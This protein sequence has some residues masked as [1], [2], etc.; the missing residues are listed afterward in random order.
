MQVPPKRALPYFLRNPVASLDLPDICCGLYIREFYELQTVL[1]INSIITNAGRSSEVLEMVRPS[2]PEVNTVFGWCHQHIYR[3][4]NISQSDAFSEFVKLITLKLFSDRHIQDTNPGVLWQDRFEIMADDVRFSQAWVRQNETNIPNP[5]SEILFKKFMDEMEH[6]IT[7]GTRKRIFEAGSQIKLKPETIQGVVKKLEK[8]FL[9]GID[10]DLNGRLFEIFLNATMRGKDLGQ[11]FT[12]R[13]VVKLG[14]KLAQLKVD[15]PLQDGSRH[16]DLVLDACCGTGGFLIDALANMQVKVDARADLADDRKQEMK[17]NIANKAIVGV[18][19]ANAPILARIARVNM[20]LHGDGGMRIFHLNA[21][22]PQLADVDTDTAEITKE[23]VELRHLFRSNSFDVVITNPPFA[24]ELDRSTDE[25]IRILDSYEIGRDRAG[26]GRSIRSM[27]LFLERYAQLLKPGGRMITVVDDGILSGD[28]YRW[29][30][31]KL[32]SWYLIKAVVSLPGDAFQR[33]NARVKTSCIVVEKRT[34]AEQKNPPVFMYPCQY[35]GNDD[36]KR[37]RPRAGD[38]E[39]RTLAEREI[40]DV[41]QAYEDFQQGRG[42]PKYMVKATRIEDRL[43]VKNCL[44]SP[45]RQES[46]WAKKGHTVRPLHEM[47]EVRKYTDDDLVTKNSEFPVTVMVVRYEGIAEADKAMNP[48]DSSYA[49]LYPVHT[50]DIVIS[51]IAASHGSIAVVP[52]DLDGCV[53]SSEYTVLTARAGFDPVILQMILRSPEIRSDILLSSSGANR[54]RTRWNLI[55]N[56]RAPYPAPEVESSI[57]QMVER[58]EEAK[59]EAARLLR[60]SQSFILSQLQLETDDADLI[61]AAFRPP[62]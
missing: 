39:L 34:N 19:I 49:K 30:K 22:D 14:V 55:R 6:D 41:V 43:D 33:S 27:L 2:L 4:D 58:A 24:K 13:S 62:K 48:A 45:G 42:N 28:E 16:T 18:D 61:L 54:T 60:D 40:I 26:A 32:R 11:F 47:L 23:K 35:V 56:L 8:L 31:D 59:R 10:A 12:P 9:F 21:L 51:N 20:Y 38:A 44:M 3:K 7:R 36:P 53:V 17:H 57:K 15:T 29:F 46:V 52:E 5:V 1:E 50:S 37:Q 25:E